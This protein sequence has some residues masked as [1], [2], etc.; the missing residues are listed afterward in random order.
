MVEYRMSASGQ[1][2]EMDYKVTHY[3]HASM[4][5]GHTNG[6]TAN[7]KS[8]KYCMIWCEFPIKDW[9]VHRSKITRVM[10]TMCVWAA[11]ATDSGHPLHAGR[12]ARPQVG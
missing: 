9:H 8:G 1:L 11:L 5:T 12:L 3:V 6:E 10:R 2:Q 7:I 4:V